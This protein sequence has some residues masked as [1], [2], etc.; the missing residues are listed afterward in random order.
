[1]PQRHFEDDEPI[2]RNAKRPRHNVVLSDDED[3]ESET[4]YEIERIK[5]IKLENKKYYFLIKWKGYPDSENSWE[6]QENLN[7]AALESI[8]H[9]PIQIAD[10]NAEEDSENDAEEDEE[11]SDDEGDDEEGTSARAQ[12][13]LETM[14]DD[15]SAPFSNKQRLFTRCLREENGFSKYAKQLATEIGMNQLTTNMSNSFE[16]PQT[17]L[18]SIVPING[19][20]C[21]VC[22]RVRTLKYRGYLSFTTKDGEKVENQECFIGPVCGLKIRFMRLFKRILKYLDANKKSI[23]E[24][25]E[26]MDKLM[27]TNVRIVRETKNYHPRKPFNM[28]MRRI[29]FGM[30]RNIPNIFYKFKT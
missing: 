19:Q 4:Q 5:A 3:D 17:S 22:N 2:R 12:F 20:I 23:E 11:D 21:D 16:L 18:S 27:E 10:S 25:N 28:F 29:K 26:I 1:M 15:F 13:L 8:S 6:P 7:P 30:D 24:I 9:I 14:E